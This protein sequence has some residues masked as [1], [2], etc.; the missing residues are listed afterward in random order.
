MPNLL[1]C[2][3]LALPWRKLQARRCVPTY[4]DITRTLTDGAV[5]PA[6]VCIDHLVIISSGPSS[7]KDRLATSA[8][9]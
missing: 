3:P 9:P 8:S 7:N 1:K 4:D 2:A 6:V 5:F